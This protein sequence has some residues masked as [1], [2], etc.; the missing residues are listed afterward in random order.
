MDDPG[1]VNGPVLILA[2]ALAA[3]AIVAVVVVTS[4]VW[5]ALAVYGVL[6]VVPALFVA[7][8]MARDFVRDE[9]RAFHPK[10]R[11][12]RHEPGSSH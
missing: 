1:R 7:V 10:A 12:S 5:T 11:W 2:Y 3:V 8:L 9:F 4:G 6:C